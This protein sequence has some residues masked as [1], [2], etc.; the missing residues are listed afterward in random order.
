MKRESRADLE[1]TLFTLLDRMRTDEITQ[2]EAEGRKY[3]IHGLCAVLGYDPERHES[4]FNLPSALQPGKDIFKGKELYL[5]DP[6]ALPALKEAMEIDGAILI[7]PDGKLMHSGKM[8]LADLRTTY[9]RHKEAFDTYKNLHETADAGTR[10]MA[11]IALSAERPDLLVYTL[12]SDHPQLRIFKEGSIYR[13]TVPEEVE[14]ESPVV[15]YQAV[16]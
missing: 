13:S 9:S 5:Q 4:Y 1:N 16:S 3:H 12:K 10:H 15:L 11:A 2:A 7:G 6:E 8:I 14:S